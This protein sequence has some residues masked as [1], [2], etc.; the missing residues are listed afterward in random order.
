MYLFRLKYIQAIRN[1]PENEEAIKQLCGD[2]FVKLN[3]DLAYLYMK[4]SV[5]FVPRGFYILKIS[6]NH[7]YVMPD[8]V[9]EFLFIQ[10]DKP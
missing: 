7:F 1:I 4:P 8:D 3:N 2:K 9:F 6:K 5:E 10:E